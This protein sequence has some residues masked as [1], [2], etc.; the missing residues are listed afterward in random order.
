MYY[1]CPYNLKSYYDNTQINPKGIKK[2][3]LGLYDYNTKKSTASPPVLAFIFI[4]FLSLFQPF[5]FFLQRPIR[6]F[7]SMC[8]VYCARYC[9]GVFCKQT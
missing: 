1:L 7:I 9:S 6:V 5:R 8:C 3:G 4:Y 2:C